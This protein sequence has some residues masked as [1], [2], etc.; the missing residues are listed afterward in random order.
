MFTKLVEKG[1]EVIVLPSAWR[2]Q[3]GADHWE[4]LVRARA[5]E[6]QCY[7]VASDQTGSFDGGKHANF[8]HSMIVD[9]WGM[10][11][12]QTSNLVGHAT[13]SV[14]LGYLRAVRARMPVRN[15][16]FFRA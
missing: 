7:V 12:A 5:I 13:A 9:P 16:D 15:H 2:F 4:I 6:T 8:G 10:V 11:V 14:D 1:A 3:T